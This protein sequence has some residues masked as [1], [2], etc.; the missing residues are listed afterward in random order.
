MT[1][2]NETSRIGV[3]DRRRSVRR[4]LADH[5]TPPAA[6][7]AALSGHARGAKYCA[8]ALDDHPGTSEELQERLLAAVA[9]ARLGRGLLV[10]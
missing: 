4:M 3:S 7:A 5:E 1:S 8:I 6:L 2:S 9:T 10:W